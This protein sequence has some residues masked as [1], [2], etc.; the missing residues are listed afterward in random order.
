MIRQYSSW[1]ETAD[2]YIYQTRRTFVVFSSLSNLGAEAQVR[3]I[4]RR[5]YTKDSQ[6]DIPWKQVPL[7]G[8]LAR[9]VTTL[10]TEWNTVWTRYY[11]LVPR[12]PCRAERSRVL[13]SMTCKSGCYRA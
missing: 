10:K 9:G 1:L 12:C 11:V 5:S 8:K 6:T 13:E 2:S 7:P 3:S 4:I